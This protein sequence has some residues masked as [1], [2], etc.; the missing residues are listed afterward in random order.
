LRPSNVYTCYIV[1]ET[2]ACTRTQ[3]RNHDL[4]RQI[5][6]HVFSHNKR[7]NFV[8]TLEDAPTHPK[9]ERTYLLRMTL[10]RN[11]ATL[12]ILA[13]VSCQYMICIIIFPSLW[14]LSAQE[15]WHSAVAQS[16][17]EPFL[18]SVGSRSACSYS[19]CGTQ[20][21]RLFFLPL[22]MPQVVWAN[23]VERPVKKIQPIS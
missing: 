20:K 16:N 9:Q 2:T 23:S 7:N 10:P 8:L 13:R 5:F 15:T 14:F 19:G 22:N 12:L 11:G 17:G 18:P 21:D 1:L 6:G 3:K 4:Q